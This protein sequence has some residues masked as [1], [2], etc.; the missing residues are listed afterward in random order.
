[1]TERIRERKETVNG[2][3]LDGKHYGMEL[4]RIPDIGALSIGQD[5]LVM[6][7]QATGQY[8]SVRVTGQLLGIKGKNQC[9]RAR[10]GERSCILGTDI[11]DGCLRIYDDRGNFVRTTKPMS[12]PVLYTE[13]MLVQTEN[14]RISSMPPQAEAESGV[15]M[16]RRQIDAWLKKFS[17][18]SK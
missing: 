5:V 12:R 15:R 11:S 13:D 2:Y 14:E 3:Y 9:V 18:K 6:V 16:V 1:M 7:E 8:Y 10:V 4:S 17:R